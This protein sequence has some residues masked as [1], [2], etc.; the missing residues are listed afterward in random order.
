MQN[1]ANHQPT[2]G[3]FFAKINDMVRYVAGKARGRDWKTIGSGALVLALFVTSISLS[4][5]IVFSKEQPAQKPAEVKLSEGKAVNGVKT[6]ANP[7]KKDPKHPDLALSVDP[8]LRKLAEYE[9]VYEGAVASTL[10]VFAGL[11]T[12]SAEAQVDA[13][14]MSTK[15]QEFARFNIRP[16]VV[17]EP[18]ANGAPVNINDY[19]AGKYDAV[20][21]EYYNNLKSHG[22][23]DAMMGTWVHFPENNIPEW[24]STDAELFKKNIVKA[25]KLQ[26]SVFPK[27]KLSILLN[28][29]SFRS[30][31]LERNYGTFSSLLPYVRGL[32]QGMFDSFGLQG[33]PWVSEANAPEQHK[34]LKPA[35][36]LNANFARE[37]AKALGTKNI[38]FNTGTFGRMY[39]QDQAKLVTY[40]P[41]QRQAIMQDVLAQVKVAQRGGYNVSVN[42][43]AYNGER[44]GEATD[45][46][47][48]HTGQSNEEAPGRLVFK[49]FAEQLEGNGGDLW[50][51]DSD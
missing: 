28:T 7:P 11:P 48:W 15:L 42:I 27:S 40:S 4:A 33:F 45:W 14:D 35:Q 34:L 49:A 32:P 19:A 8:S 31:D 18:T 37:A 20:L 5:H 23:T 46:S 24:G 2:G 47:Y 3:R 1:S 29:Q 21:T 36:F 26:K 10:M 43:F 41:Q 12:N 22:V 17:M 25:G 6:V 16:L 13:M 30:D 38:W 50:L 39:T 44:T 9:Q 51:F